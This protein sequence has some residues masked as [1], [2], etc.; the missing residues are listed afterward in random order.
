MKSGKTKAKLCLEGRLEAIGKI[1]KKRKDGLPV[2]EK[3]I[4]FRGKEWVIIG[5]VMTFPFG[6]LAFVDVVED[7]EYFIL[8]VW[9]YTK[10]YARFS[11]N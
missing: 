3:G 10:S 2:S 5:N 11:S 4:T 9:E 6:V 8:K 1:R 7:H